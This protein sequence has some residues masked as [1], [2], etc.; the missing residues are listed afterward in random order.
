MMNSC[1]S[2]SSRGF[3]VGVA[4]ALFLWCSLADAEVFYAPYA[5]S[6]PYYNRVQYLQRQVRV[7]NQNAD[8]S[9]Q[10]NSPDKSHN[11]HRNDKRADF[12]DN[13]KYDLS[14]DPI[15]KRLPA[16]GNSYGWE[17]CEFS[18]MSCLIRRRR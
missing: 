13:L 9:I 16:Y 17:Q 8:S 3:L 18:P 6:A 2:T 14:L 7:P 15:S 10:H 11:A 1:Y 5:P 12:A 4:L